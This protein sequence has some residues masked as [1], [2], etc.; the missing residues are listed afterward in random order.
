VS[1]ATLAS[2][3]AENVRRPD[4]QKIPTETATAFQVSKQ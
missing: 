1:P 2:Q 4:A 3:D